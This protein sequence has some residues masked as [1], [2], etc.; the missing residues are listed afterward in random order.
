ML[1]SA[2]NH[3]SCA[4]QDE[5]NEN[6]IKPKKIK[7]GKMGEEYVA[8]Y[9]TVNNANLLNYHFLCFCYEVGDANGKL[10]INLDSMIRVLA[11]WEHMDTVACMLRL[12]INNICN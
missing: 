5:R 2:Y 7:R 10:S 1:G 4:E 11:M 12:V 6:K 3:S 9:F 8:Y